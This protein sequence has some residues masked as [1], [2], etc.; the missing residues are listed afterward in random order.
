M[1]DAPEEPTSPNYVARSMAKYELDKAKEFTGSVDAQALTSQV[2]WSAPS[3]IYMN[4]MQ[5][6]INATGA[7]YLYGPTDF[8][9]GHPRFQGAGGSYGGGG[10]T[11]DY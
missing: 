8:N 5:N 9:F 3:N 2:D 4:Q 7:A 6:V 10:A 11:G 1:A